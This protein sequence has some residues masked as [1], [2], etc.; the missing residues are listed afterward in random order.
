MEKVI[1]I[2]AISQKDFHFQIVTGS[3]KSHDLIHFLK[4]LLKENRKKILIVWDNLSVHK[5]KVV[6]EFLKENEKRL[7]V[8][9]LPPYAPELN[10]QEY[11]W[12]RWKR[13]YMANFCPENLSSL[14]QR[15]KS[16]LAKLKSNTSSF[17]SYLRQ[18]GGNL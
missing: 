7:R 4:M 18:A 6:K 16:T 17:E 9:F 13:N 5:S 10:P 3:V 1:G 8:E 15:T 11:I 14:I 12:G 2:G